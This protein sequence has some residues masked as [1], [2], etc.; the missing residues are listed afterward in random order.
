MSA[1]NSEYITESGR[2]DSAS[3]PQH[4][5]GPSLALLEARQVVHPRMEDWSHNQEDTAGRKFAVE[6]YTFPNDPSSIPR[7][8]QLDTFSMR[9]LSH[10]KVS[11]LASRYSDSVPSLGSSSSPSVASKQSS[12]LS[13]A[14]GSLGQIYRLIPD[15]EDDE[16]LGAARPGMSSPSPAVQHPRGTSCLFSFLGCQQANFATAERWYEHSKTHFR[17]HPPPSS[18]MCPY[19]SCRWTIACDDGEEAWSERWEHLEEEHDVVADAERLCEKRD[20][21]LYE[22]LW[23]FR[24]ISGADFQELRPSGQL[25]SNK[26]P[27]VTTEK[28]PQRPRRSARPSTSGSGHLPRGR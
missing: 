22:H 10:Q 27:Y 5:Q 13:S 17:G 14:A 21:R 23:K 3:S 19:P 7:S 18:L 11:E 4:M 8:A 16:H 28:S 24:V 20:V 12:L 15:G 2:N 25:G 26:Q 1:G 9:P 6:A